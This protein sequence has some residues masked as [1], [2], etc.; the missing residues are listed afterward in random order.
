L[1]AAPRLNDCGFEDACILVAEYVSEV[2]VRRPNGIEGA[3][4]DDDF[5]QDRV[6]VVEPT[7]RFRGL[8][9]DHRDGGVLLLLGV[10]VEVS[11]EIAEQGP[12]VVAWGVP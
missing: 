12:T 2:S 11:Q 9:R 6:G 7:L 3:T 1:G 4:P 8:Q 5:T 10:F